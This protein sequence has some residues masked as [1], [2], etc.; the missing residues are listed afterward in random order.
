[1]KPQLLADLGED[2][3]ELTSEIIPEAAVLGD[4]F[5]ASG[6]EIST[7]FSHSKM[8]FTASVET[9]MNH[10]CPAVGTQWW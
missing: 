4:G 6:T 1:M 10:M 8:L 2:I 3:K 9:V 5:S 7:Y